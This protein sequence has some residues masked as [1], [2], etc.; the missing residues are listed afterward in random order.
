MG[1]PPKYTEAQWQQ[2]RD[3]KA[4]RIGLD[5]IS[6]LTG[7]K[8]S[9]VRSTGSDLGIRRAPTTA[10]L[11]FAAVLNQAI[12]M[13]RKSESL[14]EI[15]R[16]LNV[17][18]VR[19]FKY[20]KKEDIP[21]RK[22]IL[23]LTQAQRLSAGDLLKKNNELPYTR[24]LNNAE[25]AQVVGCGSTLI[26]KLKSDSRVR[27]SR[28][29][30]LKYTIEDLVAAATSSRLKLVNSQ[31]QEVVTSAVVE[32]ECH[33]SRIF[34]A[35][36]GAIIYG[37]TKSCGCLK[38]LPQKELFEFVSSLAPTAVSEYKQSGKKLDVYV[39][40]K[41]IAFEYLGLHWHGEKRA[42]SR[43]QQDRQNLLSAA[44]IRSV[45]IFDDEW[46]QHN[47]Q[48]RGYIRAILGK[49]E[50]CIGARKTE[51]DRTLT[52]EAAHDFLSTNHIQ[53]ARGA[54]PCALK[55]NGETVAVA[56]FVNIGGKNWDLVR[57]AV[58]INHR[59]QGGLSKILAAFTAD[60]KPD[61]IQTFSD[62]RWSQG[63]LYKACGFSN[64]GTVAPSYW[65]FKAGGHRQHKSEFR[66]EKIAK[67]FGP[68]LPD[69]T[70]WDAMQRLGFDRIWDCGKVKWMLTVPAAIV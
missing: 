42:G 10:D 32:V 16:K 29:Q 2:V 70:E 47:L 13:V 35:S 39:P 45:F 44:G 27:L 31:P 66:K 5:E 20:L 19:L 7:I 40:D 14:P 65:Y 50:I 18:R 53:G 63:A 21:Y 25:L 56:T 51:I 33:C 24:R 1:R 60:F 43:S 62:N 30:I 57:Y 26:K 6:R 55:I 8:K 46:L 23:D 61:S 58:K 36:I 41:K 48:V 3:L 4:Q 59:I 11:H 15:C 64:V 17:D 12:D 68:L 37:N 34:A 69:E 22:A 28:S 52:V 49:A 67:K 54:Y 38:S 9:T